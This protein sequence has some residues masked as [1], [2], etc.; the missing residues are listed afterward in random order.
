LTTLVTVIWPAGDWFTAWAAMSA[1]GPETLPAVNWVA[2]REAADVPDVGQ[3]PG[4][5]RGPEA[6]DVH[7]V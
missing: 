1:A 2:V 4:G 5:A 3:D 7:Q 6:M